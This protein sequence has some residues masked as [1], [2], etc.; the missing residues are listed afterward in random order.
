[1]PPLA[2]A[3]RPFFGGL[4]PSG[5]ERQRLTGQKALVLR[6]LG[7]KSTAFGVLPSGGATSA[8]ESAGVEMTW[9]RFNISSL[10]GPPVDHTD[11]RKDAGHAHVVGGTELGRR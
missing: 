2:A 4:S 6:R 7:P 5:F 9:G 8:Q 1:M 3:D 10:S 11:A